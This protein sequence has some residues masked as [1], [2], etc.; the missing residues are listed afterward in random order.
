MT[1]DLDLNRD[2]N[3]TLNLNPTLLPGHRI[4]T[5]RKIKMMRLSRGGDAP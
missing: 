2:L 5:E 1:S 3:L 4:E